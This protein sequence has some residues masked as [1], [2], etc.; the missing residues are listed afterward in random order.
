MNANVVP[1]TSLPSTKQLHLRETKTVDTKQLPVAIEK[2]LG[3]CSKDTDEEKKRL[4]G[5]ACH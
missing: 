4:K 5:E 3:I 1:R 2:T